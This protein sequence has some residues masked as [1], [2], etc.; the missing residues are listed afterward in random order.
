VPNLGS[1]DALV[2]SGGIGENSSNVRLS[3]SKMLSHLGIAIDEA[4]NVEGK[5]DRDISA[6]TATV[7]VLVIHTKEELAIAQS[8]WRL[9][10]T[11][12]AK[13]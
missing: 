8:A 1:L 5:D 6:A 2:F 10:L 12:G 11:S 3:V 4:K 7:K 13:V 9:Y